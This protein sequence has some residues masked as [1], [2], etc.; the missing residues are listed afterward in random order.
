MLHI[1][2]NVL[3]HSRE[4]TKITSEILPKPKTSSEAST[5]TVSVRSPRTAGI[6]KGALG[7]PPTVLHND[8]FIVED[9][10]M[11]HVLGVVLAEQY[12]ISK[13]I[14]LFGD[15]AKEAVSNELEQL[16]DYV[17]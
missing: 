15:R 10:V 3:D 16:H 5:R 8:E 14:R 11:M 17:T 1:N 4:D 6:L 2:P 7:L 9:H 12:S 13:G